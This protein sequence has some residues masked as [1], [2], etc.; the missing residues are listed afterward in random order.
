[1]ISRCTSPANPR[2]ADWGGRGITVCDSWRSFDNFLADMGER[3]AG[4][5]LERKDNECGY[6]AENCEWATPAE[7][8]RNKR[9]TKID[10]AGA[11]RIIDLHDEG[12][13]IRQISDATGFERHA[14]GVVTFTADV[15]RNE[16]R[17]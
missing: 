16:G 15:L 1:M 6:E 5:T 3:P 12:L 2:Y 13:N 11:R 8:G 14:V 4:T 9:T 7:Q 10:V 17:S